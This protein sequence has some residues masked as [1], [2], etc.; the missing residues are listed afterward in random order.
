LSKLRQYAWTVGR[1]IIVGVSV[2]LTAV[3]Y[4]RQAKTLRLSKTQ[5]ALDNEEGARRVQDATN[6]TTLANEKAAVK[7]LP[8]QV[9]ELS[10]ASVVAELRKRGLE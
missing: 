9:N 5:N 1:W 7:A 6:D 4:G 3:L 10:D 2:L 8:S